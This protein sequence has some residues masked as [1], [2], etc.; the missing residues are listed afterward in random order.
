MSALVERGGG[1]RIRVGGNTQDFATYVDQTPNNTIIAKLNQATINNPTAT[2]PVLY[3]SGLF[4]LMANVSALT[5][6]KWYLGIYIQLVVTYVH[7]R[8]T[9]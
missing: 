6:V 4:Y 3:T 1:V 5:N 2:P 9:F 8:M 7:A